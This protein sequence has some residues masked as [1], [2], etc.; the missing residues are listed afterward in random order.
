[1]KHALA[2]LVSLC[3]CLPLQ[4]QLQVGGG[5]AFGTE[6]ETLGLTAKVN[7]DIT[8]S[9]E[10][11]GSF[12][13][14]LPNGDIPNND[15]TFWEINGDGHYTFTENESLS[16]YGLAG[17]NIGHWSFENDF[18]FPGANPSDTEF[19]LNV[20][21]GIRLPFGSITGYGEIKYTISDFDQLVLNA[22]VLVPIQ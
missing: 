21:G 18:G 4:A 1:M 7:F 17:I 10:G 6:I 22:G 5:L 13:F 15:F 16:I 2:A 8:E 19:G 3:L 11:S 12:T 14:F 9:I 20:G